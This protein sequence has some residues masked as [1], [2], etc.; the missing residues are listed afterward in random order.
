MPTL[1][2]FWGVGGLRGIC[3]FCLYTEQ[4]ST[5]ARTTVGF[6]MERWQ[7]AKQKSNNSDG[8][9]E[10]KKKS[11][12]GIAYIIRRAEDRQESDVL[13]R[14]CVSVT[15]LLWRLLHELHFTPS[16][17]LHSYFQYKSDTAH[18]PLNIQTKKRCFSVWK[19]PSILY[20]S[21]LKRT[22]TWLRCS[23]SKPI[24]PDIVCTSKRAP[25]SHSQLSTDR[26][27]TYTYKFLPCGHQRPS[28]PHLL[29]SFWQSARCLSQMAFLDT[30]E[31]SRQTAQP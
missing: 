20:I 11:V 13:P 30:N 14:V 31:S 3:H 19:E 9:E 22:Y 27:C 10:G 24:S 29:F 17:F 12:G 28:T 21:T 2:F 8:E 6:Y 5:S 26:R 25:I 4:Q 18:I 23:F 7:A 16:F 1:P 15:E